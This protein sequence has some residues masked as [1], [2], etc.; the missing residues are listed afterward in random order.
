MIPYSIY[1]FRKWCQ[2]KRTENQHNKMK[3]WDELLEFQ[4]RRGHYF[5]RLHESYHEVLYTSGTTSWTPK[6]FRLDAETRQKVSRM[7]EKRKSE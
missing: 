7:S 3:K 6:C 4:G 5:D 1:D 2:H